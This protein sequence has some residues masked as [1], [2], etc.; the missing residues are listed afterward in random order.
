MGQ[1]LTAPMII[2]GV[3]LWVLAHRRA[4]ETIEA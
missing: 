1:V 4:R 3:V 2:V